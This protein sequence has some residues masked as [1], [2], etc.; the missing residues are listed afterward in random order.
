MFQSTLKNVSRNEHYQIRV[1]K[2]PYFL[3]ETRHDSFTA[4]KRTNLKEENT[5]LSLRSLRQQIQTQNSPPQP[6]VKSEELGHVTKTHSVKPQ[7][8]VCLEYS[9]PQVS[10]QQVIIG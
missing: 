8:S 7:I 6:R 3:S 9:D 5:S 2:N 10:N 1:K 4:I